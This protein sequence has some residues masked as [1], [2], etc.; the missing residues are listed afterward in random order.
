MKIFLSY[1]YDSKVL[2]IEKTKEY[3]SKFAEDTLKHE[4]LKDTSEINVDNISIT[5]CVLNSEPNIP[6]I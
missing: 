5:L 6:V 1:G 4:A 3:L 2:L